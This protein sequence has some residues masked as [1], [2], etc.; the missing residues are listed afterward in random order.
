MSDETVAP[1]QEALPL[2]PP[3]VED[4]SAA[5][6]AKLLAA[7]ARADKAE[8]ADKKRKASTAKAD[9]DAAADKAI[10]DGQAKTEIARLAAEVAASSEKAAGLEASILARVNAQIEALSDDAKAEVAAIREH[11]PLPK[12]AEFVEAKAGG[13]SSNAPAAPPTFT[14]GGEQMPKGKRKI[15]AAAKEITDQL[16]VDTSMAELAT[17]ETDPI[18]GTF[19][20]VLPI[21]VMI[22]K[23]HTQTQIPT[24]LNSEIER[25][26]KG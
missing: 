26:R 6:E 18:T 11:L 14:P 15:P 3:A 23:M 17:V 4:K 10:A 1:T 20:S 8:A 19:K 5:L 24:K 7:E 25:T 22:K 12:L 2:D 21:D 9:A 13:S 16:M